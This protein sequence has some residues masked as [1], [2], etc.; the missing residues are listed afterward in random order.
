MADALARK[1]ERR[2]IVSDIVQETPDVRSVS[3]IPV[4]GAQLPD[5]QAGQAVILRVFPKGKPESMCRAY[6]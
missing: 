4:D 5:W 1:G 6:T 2:F 3:F